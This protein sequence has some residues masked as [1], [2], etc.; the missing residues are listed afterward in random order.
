VLKQ[1][2][3]YT[4]SSRFLAQKMVYLLHKRQPLSGTKSAACLHKN[5]RFIALKAML[6]CTQSSHLFA[7]KMAD[8]FHKMRPLSGT[9]SS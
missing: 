2:F 8:L 4:K 3:Y 5:G 1:S 9:K 7:Q 6:S